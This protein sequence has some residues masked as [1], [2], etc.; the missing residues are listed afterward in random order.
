MILSW[1]FFLVAISLLA[2]MYVDLPDGEQSE[3]TPQSKWGTALTPQYGGIPVHLNQILAQARENQDSE[4]ESRIHDLRVAHFR[5]SRTAEQKEA[6]EL[7]SR[8]KFLEQ[9][10]KTGE[11]ALKYTD[12]Q[13]RIGALTPEQGRELLAQI[14][15]EEEE[16]KKNP[17]P[18]PRP[19]RE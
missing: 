17:P 19:V 2:L 10:S 3:A 12:T 5:S 1:I 15:A 13:K 4:T 11:I 8:Q 9:Y 7:I 16:A 14:L 6:Y 18:P